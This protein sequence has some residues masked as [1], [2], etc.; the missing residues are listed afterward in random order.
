MGVQEIFFHKRVFCYS[1]GQIYL[2]NIFL[3]RNH[4]A[5][6]PCWDFPGGKEE[7]LYR[8]PLPPSVHPGDVAAH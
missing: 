6:R 2:Q 8:L 1:A 5:L 3:P 7:F 4:S